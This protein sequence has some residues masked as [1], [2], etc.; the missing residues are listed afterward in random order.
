[1]PADTQCGKILV[2]DEN[3]DVR[4]LAK[5]FWEIAGCTA[6]TGGWNFWR[7]PFVSLSWS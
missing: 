6:I 1:M 3:V 7:S 4:A 2:V 5:R